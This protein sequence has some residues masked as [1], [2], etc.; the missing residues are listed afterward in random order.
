MTGEVFQALSKKKLKLTEIPDQG[1][2]LN[3]K[4]DFHSK[5]VHSQKRREPKSVARRGL[6]PVKEC[7]ESGQADWQGLLCD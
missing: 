2:S 5:P 1:S 7:R 6:C 3:K 4:R